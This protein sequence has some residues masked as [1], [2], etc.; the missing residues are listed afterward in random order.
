VANSALFLQKPK[1]DDQLP[2]SEDVATPDVHIAAFVTAINSL[3]SAGRSNA[4]TRVLTPR[5]W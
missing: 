4:P 3:L 5:K 2:V 1:F